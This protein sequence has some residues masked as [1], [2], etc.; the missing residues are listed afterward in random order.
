MQNTRIPTREEINV[1]DSLDERTACN[2]FLG[3]SIDDAQ[4]LFVENSL[5]YQEDLMFMGPAAFRFYVEAAIRYIQSPEAKYDA[6]IINCFAGILELRL[7]FES[8]QLAPVAER[9]ALACDFIIGHWDFFDVHPEL[10][11]RL[12]ETYFNLEKALAA[13][14]EQYK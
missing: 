1:F 7:K 8:E 14:G 6:D 4:R 5:R 13:L 10:Y 11:G 12:K 2:N 3:K 9:L